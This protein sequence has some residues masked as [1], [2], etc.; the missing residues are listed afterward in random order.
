MENEKLLEGEL[1]E[2]KV[3]AKS[4]QGD[5]IGKVNDQIILIKNFK[6]RLGKKYKVKITKVHDAFAYA[7]PAESSKYFIGNGG[8][9]IES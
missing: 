9:L 4:P 5:G 1:Y 7:E 6:T 2:V 8:L 3:D